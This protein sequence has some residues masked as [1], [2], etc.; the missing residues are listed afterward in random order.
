MTVLLVKFQITGIQ[1]TDSF[2]RASVTLYVTCQIVVRLGYFVGLGK[3]VFTPVGSIVFLGMCIDSQ[4]QA[5]LV[6]KEKLEKFAILRESILAKKSVSLKVL[7]RFMGKCISFMLAVPCTRLYISDICIALSENYRSVSFSIVITGTLKDEVIFGR[8]VD[9]WDGFLPWKLEK[10]K[11]VKLKTDSSNYKWA[12]K[13]ETNDINLEFGDYWP[14]DV[15]DSHIIVKEARA[16]I[17]SLKSVKNNYILDLRIDILCDCKS[18]IDEWNG[19]G[20]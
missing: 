19:Q 8:F 9:N 7:Q 18:F 11:V 14:A 2:L 6:P 5:F 4:K 12:R 1:N 3:S 13:F 17:L 20:S 16:I 10:H 15:L